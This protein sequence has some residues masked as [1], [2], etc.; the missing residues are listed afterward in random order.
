MLILLPLLASHKSIMT[1][2]PNGIRVVLSVRNGKLDAEK[3]RDQRVMANRRE[4]IRMKKLNSA[5]D[6]LRQRFP[7]PSINHDKRSS[8]LGS[9]L[10]QT[11][12]PFKLSKIDILRL[13]RNYI[14][15]LTQVTQRN[16]PLDL[17]TYQEII[18]FGISP[19][20]AT[21]IHYMFEVYER[22]PYAGQSFLF[23]DLDGLS[24]KQKNVQIFK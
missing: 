21:S 17:M 8:R 12:E 18:T 9:S 19:A 11:F 1:R 16:D 15:A 3:R 5:L 10:V 6:Q 13:A 2:V 7:I 24:K 14:F 20:A 22:S 4:R 23:G